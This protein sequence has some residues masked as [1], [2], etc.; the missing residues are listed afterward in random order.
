MPLEEQGS[1][2]QTVFQNRKP[3]LAL[4]GLNNPCM[5]CG[6]DIFHFL[7]PVFIARGALYINFLFF[8]FHRKSNSLEELVGSSSALHL[9]TRLITRIIGQRAAKAC[10]KGISCEAR[11]GR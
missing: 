4:K 6:G 1:T 5:S 8:F 10:G 11:L 2:W 3:C 7:L 9:Q